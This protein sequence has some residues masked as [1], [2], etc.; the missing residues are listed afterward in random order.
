MS[1]D[2]PGQNL[3]V[4]DRYT[5]AL[6]EQIQLLDL[7]RHSLPP[8]LT[9]AQNPVATA[10]MAIPTGPAIPGDARER[11]AQLAKAPADSG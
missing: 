2:L 5:R 9:T 10:P 4:L 1:L 11:P 7:I 3:Q 6:G 8:L